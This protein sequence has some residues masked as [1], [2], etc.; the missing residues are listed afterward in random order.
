MKNDDVKSGG[1][2]LN[3]GD[4]MNLNDVHSKSDDCAKN[5]AR[6]HHFFVQF[7]NLNFEA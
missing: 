2:N 4:V 5:G 1:K 6:L 3:G 7:Q